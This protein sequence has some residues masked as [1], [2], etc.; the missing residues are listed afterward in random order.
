MQLFP[1]QVILQYEEVKFRLIITGPDRTKPMP[2]RR[3]GNIRI[4]VAYYYLCL[5]QS[6]SKHQKVCFTPVTKVEKMIVIFCDLFG[7]I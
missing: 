4:C 5:Y 2:L 1:T 6:L 7:A 3:V